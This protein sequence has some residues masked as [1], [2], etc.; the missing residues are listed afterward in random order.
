M[1][2]HS[3]STVPLESPCCGFHFVQRYKHA[4]SS[5]S[6]HT[7]DNT[8]FSL[9]EMVCDAVVKPI[10]RRVVCQDMSALAHH[11]DVSGQSGCNA[12]LASSSG[13][14]TDEGETHFM[15]FAN[16][17]DEDPMGFES[18]QLEQAPSSPSHEV[19]TGRPACSSPTS[20]KTSSVWRSSNAG[21]RIS[22]LNTCFMTSGF[23]KQSRIQY[24]ALGTIGN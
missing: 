22:L 14:G 17:D 6:S 2:R 11:S 10:L 16:S 24:L 9:S 12:G 4:S 7:K 15:C 3:C 18:C 21:T 19:G 8:H 5:R 1:T 23:L 13:S 20:P